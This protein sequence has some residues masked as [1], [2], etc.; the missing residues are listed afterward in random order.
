MLISIQQKTI[1]DTFSLEGVPREAYYVGMAGVL[2]YLATSLS[3]V[4][5]AWEINH[6]AEYGTGFLM[7]DKT[8][9]LALHVIEP[10]QIG[11]GAVV[12]LPPLLDHLELTQFRSSPSSAP[13]TGASNGLAT[14]V[15]K[16]TPATPLASSAPP[17]P[18]P[19]SSSRPNTP[20]SPNSSSST[21]FTTP[22]RAPRNAA[23]ALS[24]T[25]FTA[26]CSHSSLEAPLCCL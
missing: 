26:S 12:S 1:R 13:F 3:T 22:T 2:P 24:G 11:Y 18:G 17:S 16:A 15:T 19:P 4:Y 20:S 23:G 7:S 10:L 21:S 9:E 5:C 8:A 25:A 14:A 6:S